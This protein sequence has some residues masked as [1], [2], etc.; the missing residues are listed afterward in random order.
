MEE[1]NFSDVKNKFAKRMKNQSYIYFIIS[2]LLFGVAYISFK[3]DG[4][5]YY[6]SACFILL[7]VLILLVGIDTVK[8]SR[9]LVPLNDPEI[10]KVYDKALSKA[11]SK[12]RIV[13]PKECF[14]Y[15][16]KVGKPKENGYPQAQGLL[17]E[18]KDGGFHFTEKRIKAW[19]FIGGEPNILCDFEI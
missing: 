15:L 8:V 16:T 4:S 10:K 7:G 17:Y 1:L 9:I 19:N 2:L 14:Y 6:I 13:S 5:T 18:G 12:E 3:G 11:A